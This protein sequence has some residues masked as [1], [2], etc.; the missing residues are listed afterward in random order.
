VQHLDDEPSQKGFVTAILR[1]ALQKGDLGTFEME[2]PDW[3]ARLANVIHA[4][5]HAPYLHAEPNYDP[6]G[7]VCTYPVL[8]LFKSSSIRALMRESAPFLLITLISIWMVITRRY[9]LAVNSVILPVCTEC[10]RDKTE[11]VAVW[12]QVMRLKSFAGD[13]L[14]IGAMGILGLVTYS[15]GVPVSILV[16]C[17]IR[18]FKLHESAT[19]RLLG[20]FVA[21][22]EP[23]YFWWA[24]LVKRS[25]LLLMFFVAYSSTMPTPASKLMTFLTI[26]VITFVLHTKCRPFD[27][28]SCM[29][30]DRLES[31]A[32]LAR[33]V[34]FFCVNTL[35]A[36][37][38]SVQRNPVTLAIFCGFP[39]IVNFY[40][41]LLHIIC[42]SSEICGRRA[43]RAKHVLD[44]CDR[45]CTLSTAMRLWRAAQYSIILYLSMVEDE[46]L[47]QLRKAPVMA[48]RCVDGVKFANRPAIDPTS[49]PSLLR[50]FL[51]R[52]LVA[53]IY[54]T[55]AKTQRFM[56][57]MNLHDIT[58]FL[59]VE[60]RFKKLPGELFRFV[61]S[62]SAAIREVCQDPA[63]QH[64][65]PSE[66][67]QA[68]TSKALKMLEPNNEGEDP[69]CYVTAEDV[70]EALLFL[71]NLHMNCVVDMFTCIFMHSLDAQKSE[72]LENDSQHG[73]Q[74]FKIENG[75]TPAT[76]LETPICCFCLQ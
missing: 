12:A 48:W 64:E 15:I 4:S 41:V 42:I 16:M 66:K 36:L 68:I 43:M 26:S 75:E 21:G 11:K 22:L 70:N 67:T 45:P 33:C 23:S 57:L 10:D 61:T 37:D 7:D 18:R 6:S 28:R 44:K 73:N 74:E 58:S 27:N 40:V 25:D 31:N 5:G 65:L 8:G 17:Y 60:C 1:S 14:T 46:K 19:R 52:P 51:L 24:L 32:L 72:D 30:A 53:H 54:K 49:A 47:A 63:H 3:E 59:V 34:F 71:Q 9:M 20:Y 50:R 39:I 69:L 62:L 38:T 13:H 29:L 2:S 56:A 35:L 76:A 55:D